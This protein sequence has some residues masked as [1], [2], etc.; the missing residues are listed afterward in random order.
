[1]DMVAL[2]V[3]VRLILKRGGESPQ[4]MLIGG[5]ASTNAP[6]YRCK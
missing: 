1:M 2:R 6:L 5:G 4:P 3:F